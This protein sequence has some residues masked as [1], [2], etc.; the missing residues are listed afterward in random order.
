MPSVGPTD[1]RRFCEIDEWS[2]LP[3]ARGKKRDHDYFEKRLS[4]GDILRTKVSRNKKEYGEGFWRMVWQRQLG[5]ER[6]EQFWEALKTGKPVQRSQEVSAPEKP[7]IPFWLVNVLVHT[8]RIPLD[9]VKGMTPDEAQERWHDYQM[10][11]G[12]DDS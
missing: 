6:E 5:L 1:H 3:S 4:S 2:E 11:A 12:A 8:V 9:E 7:T 10:S